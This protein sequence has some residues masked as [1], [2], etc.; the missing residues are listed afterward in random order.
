MAM[1][2]S[3]RSLVSLY[4]WDFLRRGLSFA[5]RATRSGTQK[6]KCPSWRG[7]ATVR[8]R[9]AGRGVGV[10]RSAAKSL[11]GKAD[12]SGAGFSQEGQT[13]ERTVEE[14]VFHAG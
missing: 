4:T 13:A 12:E 7:K 11:D 2:E 14:K 1:L 3:S 5:L 8:P 10:H 9:S 6:S